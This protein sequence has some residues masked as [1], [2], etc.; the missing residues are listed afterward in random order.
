MGAN[1]G[2]APSGVRPGTGLQEVADFHEPRRAFA[3]AVS[4]SME[5]EFRRA[6][7][8]MTPYRKRPAFVPLL[9]WFSF[10]VAAQSTQQVAKNLFAD[11]ASAQNFP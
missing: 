10:A 11:P 4:I 8:A 9:V 7:C 2:R 6:Q 1:I 3:H 5:I